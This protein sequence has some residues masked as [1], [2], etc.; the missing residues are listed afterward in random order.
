L[1]VAPSD[2]HRRIEQRIRE[3]R[4]SLAKYE[5]GAAHLDAAA[6]ADLTK[7]VH[8]IGD[9][10]LEL[11]GRIDRIEDTREEWTTRGWSP[12]PGGEADSV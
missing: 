11:S 10:L 12:P 1:D 2:D 3:L 5:S 7:A 9:H 6:M 8:D 4:A